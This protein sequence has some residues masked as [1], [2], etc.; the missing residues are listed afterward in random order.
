MDIWKYFA[1][2]HQNHVFCNP[3]SE[4]KFAEVIERLDLP[5]SARVLD[6][7]CGKAELLV[8][9]ARRWGCSGVG[10][11]V[12]PPFVAEA[13]A[14]VAAAGFGDA[15]EIVEC[16]GSQYDAS[17]GAF[18]AAMCIGASWIF[19]GH[20]KT[21]EAM[22][23]HAKPGGLVIVGEPFFI[24]E[25]SAEYLK[26]AGFERDSFASHPGNVRTG[27]DQGL[28]FLHA[29]ASSHDDWDRYEG[30]QC[31]AAERYAKDNPDDPDVPAI[32][33]GTRKARD[34]YLRW[35]RDALGWAVYL[36]IKDPVEI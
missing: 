1:V 33:T 31:D 26:A 17:P 28:G 11:D 8:R 2:G 18:D 15:I 32:L 27:L 12:S 6:I 3:L 4:A 35:G 24:G 22:S 14:N 20:A 10:V 9:I 36:F 25:P 34:E 13:R 19:G 21:L 16:E 7:A 23:R 29:V 30:L 5:A